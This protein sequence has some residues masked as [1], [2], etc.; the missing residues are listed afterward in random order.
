MHYNPFELYA[1]FSIVKLDWKNRRKLVN[2]RQSRNGDRANERDCVCVCIFD[3]HLPIN[4]GLPSIIILY[5][6]TNVRGVFSRL[7]AV[8]NERED[9]K[10]I[11]KAKNDTKTR[12][13]ERRRKRT[14]DEKEDEK[15]EEDWRRKMTLRRKLLRREE[16]QKTKRKMR[17]EEKEEWR[18]TKEAAAAERKKDD[19][20]TGSVSNHGPGYYKQYNERKK[21]KN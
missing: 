16:R 3:F 11:S 14:N 10:R 7:K 20:E 6:P 17:D 4:I 9:E 1:K 21:Y 18:E 5:R 15:Q 19:Q 8:I 13:D 2:I 12:K